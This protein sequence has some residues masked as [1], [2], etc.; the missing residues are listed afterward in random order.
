MAAPNAANKAR[1][2]VLQP[3]AALVF[4]ERRPEHSHRVGMSAEQLQD[5]LACA[6]PNHDPLRSDAVVRCQSASQRGTGWIGKRGW[7]DPT[8][9]VDYGGAGTE[10][11]GI[12]REITIIP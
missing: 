12:G 7:I 3:G 6:G 5:Q 1:R 11:V 9:P 2:A 4:G 10:R 8:Q